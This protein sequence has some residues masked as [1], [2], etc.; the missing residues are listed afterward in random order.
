MTELTADRVRDV[1]FTTMSRP[2]LGP[3]HPPI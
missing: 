3:T 1:L 2:A